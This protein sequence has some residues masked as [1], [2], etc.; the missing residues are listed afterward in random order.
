MKFKEVGR[1]NPEA[2]NHLQEVQPYDFAQKS[3]LRRLDFLLGIIKREKPK[4]VTEYATKLC[5]KFREKTITIYLEQDSLFLEEIL[6]PFQNLQVYPN[7]A[8]Y[9]LN[10]FPIFIIVLIFY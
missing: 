8:Y 10:F 5:N 6:E 3:P 7:L 9:N 1:Y 4:I 2:L